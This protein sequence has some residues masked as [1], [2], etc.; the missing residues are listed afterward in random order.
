MTRSLLTASVF[1]LFASTAC[2]STPATITHS[3]DYVRILHGNTTAVRVRGLMGRV[4]KG[5]S[6]ADFETLSDDRDRKIV[7]LLGGDGLVSLV[8]ATTDEILA[9]VGYTR[10]YIAR[11]AHDGYR[12]KLV[13]FESTPGAEQLAT[14]DHV[15]DLVAR[16]YPGIGRRIEAALPHL[17]RTSFAEIERQAPTRFSD[18][19]KVGR[20]HAD[21]VDEQRLRASDGPLWRVRGFLYYRVRVMELFAGDGVTRTADGT[22]G[23]KEYIGRNMP[24]RELPGA[25]LVD[26]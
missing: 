18:V 14:W 6:D 21:Y 11:L 9:K 1:V 25:R 20:D 2:V 3:D 19:D 15:V 17:Q 16:T 12:F 26:L 23:L 5:K 24:I 13:V 10:E 7:F 8:G 22:R 4:L